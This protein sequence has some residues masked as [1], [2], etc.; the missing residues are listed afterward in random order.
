LIILLSLAAVQAEH[1]I[2][3]LMVIT[4]EITVV[5]V[6]FQTL[7]LLAVVAAVNIQM[8]TV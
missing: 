4:L 5:Q 3:L 1:M 7:L 6:Y 8:E 2:F